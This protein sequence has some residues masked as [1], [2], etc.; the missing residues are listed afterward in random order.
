[1]K[2]LDVEFERGSQE[3]WFSLHWREGVLFSCQKGMETEWL[4]TFALFII[5]VVVAVAVAVAVV[6]AVAVAVAVAVVVARGQKKF[7]TYYDRMNELFK[8]LFLRKRQITVKQLCL[9]ILFSK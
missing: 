7:L 5:I 4:L 1:M 2:D 9:Q 3:Q 8:S 6:V